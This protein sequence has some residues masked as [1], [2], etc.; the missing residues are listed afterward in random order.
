[1]D[2][3]LKAQDFQ[4]FQ[5]DSKPVSGSLSD[6]AI[7]FDPVADHEAED[8]VSEGTGGLVCCAVNNAGKVFQ[9]EEYV[10]SLEGLGR[11]GDASL[12]AYRLVD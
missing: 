4:F 8:C 9:L 11:G 1:M 12:D 10:S 6:S 5:V 2:I 7:S 3:L